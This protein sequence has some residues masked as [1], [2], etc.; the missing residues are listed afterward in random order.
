MLDFHLYFPQLFP[1]QLH[2]NGFKNVPTDSYL[3]VSLR[4]KPPRVKIRCKS[5]IFGT[6]LITELAMNKHQSR[7]QC[8]EY[9]CQSEGQVEQQKS[10]VGCM[11]KVFQN[12][13]YAKI[14]FYALTGPDCGP[15]GSLGWKYNKIYIN[16]AV[17]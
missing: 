7:V 3:S 11:S 4:L 15:W 2:S 14:T 12:L 1:N 17:C 16:F 9:T 13:R 10:L 5:N 6:L 8:S